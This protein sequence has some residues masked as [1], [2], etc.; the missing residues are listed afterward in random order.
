MKDTFIFDL[1]GTLANSNGRDFYNPFDEEI[2][3]DLHITPVCKVVKA[4]SDSYNIVFLSGREAKFYKPTKIWIENELRIFNPELWMRKTGDM[5]KDSIIKLEL[6]NDKIKPNYNVIGVFDDRLQVCRMWYEQ[7]IFCFN[8]N[9]G[10][11][12]F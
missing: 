11:K 2:I 9:Q 1:D 3:A 10:L 6:F 5:R 7:G 4:L 8:V 12:E